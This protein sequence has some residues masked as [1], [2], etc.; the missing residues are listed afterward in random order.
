MTDRCYTQPAN[1]K[2]QVL[3]VPWY[4][5]LHGILYHVTVWFRNLPHISQIQM[6]AFGSNCNESDQVER[7][8]QS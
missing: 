3:Q 2:G 8:L 4:F 6:T 7:S 1:Y 5:H